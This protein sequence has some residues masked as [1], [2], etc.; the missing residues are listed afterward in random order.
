[1]SRWMTRPLI[2]GAVARGG[3]KLKVIRD[4]PSAAGNGDI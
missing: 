4:P 1:V 3:G 2:T